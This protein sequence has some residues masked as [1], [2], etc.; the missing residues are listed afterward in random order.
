M[1]IGDKVIKRSNKPFKCGLKIATICEFC[2]N[3]Y[4]NKQAVKIKE[5]NSIVDIYILKKIN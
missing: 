4:T 3:P 1:D 5:D 2:I